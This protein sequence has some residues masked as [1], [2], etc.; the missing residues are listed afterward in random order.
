MIS[1]NRFIR[2]LGA[3]AIAAV[4]GWVLPVRA[5]AQNLLVNGGFET[6]D[7]TGWT[8]TSADSG[9]VVGGVGNPNVPDGVFDGNFSAI[10]GSSA[11]SD[12][13]ESVTTNPGATYQLSFELSNG[14]GLNNSFQA[15]IDGGVLLTLTNAPAFGWTNYSFDFT[16]TLAG[17]DT[18]DFASAQPPTYW[19]LDDVSVTATV[20]EPGVTTILCGICIGAIAMALRSRRKFGLAAQGGGHMHASED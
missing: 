12:L 18:V 17:S 2:L 15:L 1:L 20:P 5:L 4:I 7:F 19:G 9:Y 14:S 10:L 3:F 16:A 13:S 8:I 11:I 6:G